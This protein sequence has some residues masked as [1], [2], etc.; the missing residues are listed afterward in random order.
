ME[1]NKKHMARWQGPEDGNK[2]VSAEIREP[3]AATPRR[4]NSTTLH[5]SCHFKESWPNHFGLI[6][7]FVL[8]L[9]IVTVV[10]VIAVNRTTMPDDPP[11]QKINDGTMNHVGPMVV[12]ISLLLPIKTPCF[13]LLAFLSPRFLPLLPEQLGFVIN[14]SDQH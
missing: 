5:L 2:G 7:K 9:E 11:L 4:A 12:T 14:W 1:I 13:Y 6:N 10:T 8:P 3:E